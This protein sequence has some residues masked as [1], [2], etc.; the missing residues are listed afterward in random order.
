MPEINQGRRLEVLVIDDDPLIRDLLKE[1][2][3]PCGAN[4]TTALNG[5]DGIEKYVS[6]F[7]GGKPYDAVFTDLNMP[8]ASGIEVVKRIKGISQ[9]TPVYV[10]TGRQSDDTYKKLYGLLGQLGPDGVIQ[11]PFSL[12]TI[13]E[14]IKKIK[15]DKGL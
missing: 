3:E 11:K 12:D 14:Y 4:V 9:P 2:I 13:Q 1:I 8:E 7:N 6:M 5:K 10:V 15:S